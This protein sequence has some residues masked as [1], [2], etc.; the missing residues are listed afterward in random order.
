[1][2]VLKNNDEKYSIFNNKNCRDKTFKA[3]CLPV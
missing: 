3:T 1:M 2:N